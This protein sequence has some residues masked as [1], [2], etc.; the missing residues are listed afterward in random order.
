M[1]YKAY[2]ILILIMMLLLGGMFILVGFV[3][4]WPGIMEGI[5][6]MLV[7]VGIAIVVGVM[8]SIGFTATQPTKIQCPYCQQK[9][10][11]KVKWST[12]HLHLSRLDED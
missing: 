10:V 12:G 5:W 9:I 8:V 2:D 6:W 11:P 4:R 7:G 1:S 3:G